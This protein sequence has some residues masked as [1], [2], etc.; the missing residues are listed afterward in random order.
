M[1]RVAIFVLVL[2]TYGCAGSRAV[3]RVYGG[4]VRIEGRVEPEEYARVL[5]AAADAPP[6]SETTSERADGVIVAD[7]CPRVRGH[8]PAAALAVD[9]A[10]AL[11]HE[12]VARKRARCVG[13][14]DDELVIRA[15]WYGAHRLATDVARTRS[16]ADP[17][18]RVVWLGPNE[19]P[20]VLSRTPLCSLWLAWNLIRLGHVEAARALARD[21]DAASSSDP[22]VVKLASDLAREGVL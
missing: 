2:G 9:D 16:R 15:W 18:A 7:R 22:L 6:V 13:M 21:V 10:L 14:K 17:T 4:E 11:G 19:V 20:I 8:T 12:D 5:L 3:T 1:N